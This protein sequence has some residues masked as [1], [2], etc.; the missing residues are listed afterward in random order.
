MIDCRYKKLSGCLLLILGSMSTVSF[1]SDEGSIDTIAPQDHSLESYQNID[2]V[3]EPIEKIKLATNLPSESKSPKLSKQESKTYLKQNPEEF[4]KLLSLLLVQGN[5]ESLEELL[6]VYQQVPNYDPSVIDWGQAII[7]AQRGDFDTAVALYRTLNSQ[8]P[9]VDILRFQ[10]AMA[11]FYNQQFE[12]AKSEFEK[13]RSGTESEEDIAVINKYLEAINDQDSWDVYASISYLDDSN[14]TNSPEQGIQLNNSNS[15]VTYTSPREEGRGLNYYLS[16]DKK[17]RKDNKFFTALHLNS[18]GKYY[19]DNKKYNDV[20][21][22]VRAGIGFQ[23]AGTEAE[24]GPFYNNRWYGQGN[25]GD[26]DLHTYADTVGMMANV[27]QWVNPK[28]RYQGLI[29]YGKTSYIEQYDHNDGKD[30]YLSNTGIYFPNGQQFWIF[31]L[32]Y[33]NKKADKNSSSFDRTGLRLGWGQTWPK[34]YSTKFN[35]GYA[36]RDYDAE[37]FFG[38]KRENEEYSAGVSFWKRD[39]TIF[40]LTPRFELDYYKVESNSPFE[41]YDKTNVSVEFTKSF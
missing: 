8:L 34:G 40:G 19:W 36:Q 13:L 18:Y 6:P 21:A 37:D 7:A 26:G 29:R 16:A 27:N 12:A 35:I 17:W 41:E 38:I 22:G 33:S 20:T 14:I 23:N 1:A 3:V 31:G 9:N 30:L 5:A 28:L 11:L 32:D 15:N 4:E 10:M 25:S 24:I 39:F 2:K